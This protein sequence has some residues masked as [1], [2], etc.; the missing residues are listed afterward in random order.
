MKRFKLLLAGIFISICSFSQP[1]KVLFIGNS[2]TFYSNTPDIFTELSESSGK[3]V[4]VEG[5]L[6]GGASL[7]YHSTLWE[8]TTKINSQKWDYVILQGSS[9]NIA[10]PENHHIIKPPIVQLM[11]TIKANSDDTE[12]I[13]FLDWA[14]K[15]GV[16]INGVEYTYD[17]FQWMI[18]EGTRQLSYELGLMIAPVGWAWLTVVRNR[19][20]IDLFHPDLGHPS[21]YGAYLSACVYFATIFGE[22]LDSEYIG[23]I[24]YE[25]AKFLQS[26]GSRTVLDNLWLWNLPLTTDFISDENSPDIILKPNYPNPIGN[27]TTIDY[28]LNKQAYVE[29]TIYDY[30]GREIEK[31][32]ASNHPPGNYSIRWDVGNKVKIP[33]G[34][35]YIVLTSEKTQLFCKTLK[36]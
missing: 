22:S 17:D 19:P 12:I 1:I 33:G 29:I 8:T 10:F 25:E 28:M 14:M 4:Y 21:Y 5:S 20:D 27:Y 30:T 2:L 31:L 26:T 3:D 15:N 34:F 24:S 36:K 11:S 35:Y 16:T 23:N 32:I 9:Y 7:N 13:F 18:M 6:Y